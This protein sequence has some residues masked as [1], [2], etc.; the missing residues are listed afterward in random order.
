MKLVGDG[1]KVML[2]EF[3]WDMNNKNMWK[4]VIEQVYFKL[5]YPWEKN[6]HAWLRAQVWN[7]W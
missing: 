3:F 1:K 2:Y 4:R 6:W 7:I 5:A